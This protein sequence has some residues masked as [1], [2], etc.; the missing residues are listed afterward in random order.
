MA[1]AKSKYISCMYHKVK[2]QE[3]LLFFKDHKLPAL[4][5]AACSMSHFDIATVDAFTRTH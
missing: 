2:N 5:K 3:V 4:A 1:F